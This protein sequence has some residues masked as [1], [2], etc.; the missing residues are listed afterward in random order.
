M[1]TFLK[2]FHQIFTSTSNLI[3]LEQDQFEENLLK[4]AESI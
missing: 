3:L 1:E 4:I 2:R